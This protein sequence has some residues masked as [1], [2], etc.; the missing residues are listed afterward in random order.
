MLHKSFMVSFEEGGWGS[1]FVGIPFYCWWCQDNSVCS[2]PY[3][4]PW[5]RY[6]FIGIYF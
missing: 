3:H 6:K 1:I 5:S 2:H 4:L